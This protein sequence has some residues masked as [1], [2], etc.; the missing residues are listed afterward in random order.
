MALRKP[1]RIC[2]TYQISHDTLHDNKMYLHCTY[3]VKYNTMFG[4]S[5]LRRENNIYRTLL[6]HDIKENSVFIKNASFSISHKKFRDFS[7]FLSRTFVDEP[8]FYEL[9]SLFILSFC[10]KRLSSL[11]NQL[12]PNI[13]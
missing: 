5:W 13:C 3:Y 10:F 11:F 8:I 7:F 12:D 6:K 9:L 4:S 2:K 1:T